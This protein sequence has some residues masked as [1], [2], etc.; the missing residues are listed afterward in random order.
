MKYSKLIAFFIGSF[1]LFTACDDD[2]N[3]EK[4][5]NLSTNVIT[6]F[7]ASVEI[8]G[9][10]YNTVSVDENSDAQFYFSNLSEDKLLFSL[11]ED[12]KESNLETLNLNTLISSF[13]LHENYPFLSYSLILT[14]ITLEDGSGTSFLV[15]A[16]TV[17]G[18]ENVEFYINIDTDKKHWIVEPTSESEKVSNLV[19]SLEMVQYFHDY[20]EVNGIVYAYL[21]FEENAPSVFYFYNVNDN[22]EELELSIPSDFS[23]SGM[24]SVLAQELFTNFFAHNQHTFMGVELN[25]LGIVH[26]DGSGGSFLV[27]ATTVDSDEEVVFYLN[28]NTGKQ[29]W[30]TAP[31]K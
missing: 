9:Q 18:D 25:L 20:K 19:L 31:T 2:K 27:L 24:S 5:L 1:F 30:S 12:F 28:T 8:E 17:S 6:S 13:F 23:L 10:T 4:N 26:E 3:I 21:S 7:M 14:E 11:P 29:H 16:T 22:K 15:K